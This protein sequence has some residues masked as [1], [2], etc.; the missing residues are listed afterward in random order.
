MQIL[1]KR[2]MAVFVLKIEGRF[3]KQDFKTRIITR[4]K[5]GHFTMIKW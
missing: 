4:D 1:T 3:L 2:K 5:K